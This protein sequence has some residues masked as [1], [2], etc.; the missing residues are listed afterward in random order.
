MREEILRPRGLRSRH[1]IA[2][3]NIHECDDDGDCAGGYCVGTVCVECRNDGDCAGGYCVGT[4]CAECRND[5]DCPDDGVFCNGGG[6]AG[7]R[8]AG[9]SVDGWVPA[10]LLRRH[11]VIVECLNDGDCPDDGVFCNGGEICTAGCA[12]LRATPV[13]A[14]HGVRPRW[15]SGARCRVLDHY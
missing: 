6:Y 10:R 13:R 2:L 5:G 1:Y 9:T 3:C 8:P 14:K 12:H 7:G 4:V 11:R 15:A